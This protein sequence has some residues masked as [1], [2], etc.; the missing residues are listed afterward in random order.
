MDNEVGVPIE[1]FSSQEWM[2]IPLLI[3]LVSYA[4]IRHKEENILSHT[5]RQFFSL[6]YSNQSFR[7]EQIQTGGISG[8]LLF[9]SFFAV[10]ILLYKILESV[11]FSVNPYLLL[12]FIVIGMFIWIILKLGIVSLIKHVTDSG[13]ALNQSRSYN[14]RYY[15]VVGVL[16]VPG[17]VA[18]LFLPET[19]NLKVAFLSLESQNLGYFY[20]LLLIAILY[21]F[22][23]LQNIRQSFETKISWYYI[24]LYLCTLE[25]LP[26]VVVYRLL[27]GKI[28]MFN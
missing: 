14:F 11:W 12:L 2:L 24:I 6:R 22:K 23:L 28:G 25:I 7:E 17:L 27:V 20:S 15:E 8:L 19:M 21:I 9:N 3:L 4:L 16:L 26:L 5:L 10:A 18:L 1:K 13:V